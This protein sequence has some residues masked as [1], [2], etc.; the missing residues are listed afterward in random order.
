MLAVLG[1]EKTLLYV[2]CT[3]KF[4]FPEA[5]YP[6]TYTDGFE[7]CRRPMCPTCACS[8]EPT[9]VHY[10]CCRIFV[11]NSSLSLPRALARLHFIGSFRNPWPRAPPLHLET[12]HPFDSTALEKVVDKADLSRLRSLP[13]EIQ[14]SVRLLTLESFLWRFA[15]T[16]SAARRVG[17]GPRE[18]LPLGSV[19]YFERGMRPQRL[20]RPLQA[21]FIRLSIDADGIYKIERL[22][23]RPVAACSEMLKS[24]AYIVEAE[25]ALSEV[26]AVFEVYTQVSS[27]R[28]FI[29]DCCK[30]WAR[31]APDPGVPTKSDH[32]GHV[33][34]PY[35]SLSLYRHDGCGPGTHGKVAT[36]QDNRSQ[37]DS[38]HNILLLPRTAIW[39]SRPQIERLVCG[40]DTQQALQTTS[41][42][43]RL[44]LSSYSSRRQ[45][46]SVGYS[47][48]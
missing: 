39:Y 17:K 15:A 38:R 3:R 31:Q 1:D 29:S 40:I 13:V 37:P 11:Q 9:T 4:T 20:V 26:T 48:G 19:K 32:L 45:S 6:V 25:A 24:V 34:A 28:S 47:R 42:F 22:H 46:R 2:G 33:N 10:D 7:L 44:D 21:S 43:L 41:R 5:G 27:R 16:I 30:G 36:L 23:T 8:P 14:E 12:S 18:V 35:W